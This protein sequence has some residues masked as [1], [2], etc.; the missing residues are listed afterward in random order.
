MVVTSAATGASKPDPAPFRVALERLELA[1]GQ[2]LHVGDTPEA[3]G[4]GAREAGIDVRIIDREGGRPGTIARLTEV[5]DAAVSADPHSRRGLPAWWMLPPAV[6]FT[7]NFIAAN[8]ATTTDQSNGVYKASYVAAAAV[9]ALVIG[10]YA[11]FAAWVSKRSI[12]PVLAIRSVAP[13]RAAQLA[14]AAFAVILGSSLA[15]EPLLHG[16]EAQGI[17]PDR[18]PRDGSEWALLAVAIAVLVLLVPICEELLF[19][20][21]GFA[22]FGSHA[23]GLTAGPV[24]DRARHDP[25][26]AGGRHRR[27]RPGRGA[28]PIGQR[29]AWNGSARGGQPDGADDRAGHR[30]TSVHSADRGALQPTPPSRSTAAASP[31]RTW[32]SSAR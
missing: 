10:A 21:L 28:A 16:D 31:S 15:L 12:R 1:P 25:R 4:D 30:L 29:V 19:R 13:M 5:A 3:D 7:A 11:L 18:G 6:V 17:A 27:P 26:A 32:R 22:A 14:A 20:G 8:L 9:T 2:A 23:L 24:R